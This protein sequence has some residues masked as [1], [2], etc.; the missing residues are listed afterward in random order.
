LNYLL[1]RNIDRIGITKGLIEDV[2][3]SF[4]LLSGDEL[5]KPGIVMEAVT[6]LLTSDQGLS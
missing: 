1:T 2:R 4:Y 6:D 3:K 5:N